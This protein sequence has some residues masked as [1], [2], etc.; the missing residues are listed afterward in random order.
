MFNRS[1]EDYEYKRETNFDEY[2]E[3]MDEIAEQEYRSR[4]EEFRND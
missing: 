3:A 1:Y 4:M 2:Y